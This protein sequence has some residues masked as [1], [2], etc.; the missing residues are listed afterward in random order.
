MTGRPAAPGPRT[1]RVPRW[2]SASHGRWPSAP[3]RLPAAGPFRLGRSPAPPPPQL[4]CSRSPGRWSPAERPPG[5]PA[6]PRT[7]TGPAAP[8]H[9]HRFRGSSAAPSRRPAPGATRSRARRAARG[10]GGLRPA[11]DGTSGTGSAHNPR[12]RAVADG[13]QANDRIGTPAGSRRHPGRQ[14]PD[15]I[16]RQ[17]ATTATTARCPVLD[18]VGTRSCGRPVLAPPTT[19]GASAQ[20]PPQHPALLARLPYPPPLGPL[21]PAE[22]RLHRRGPVGTPIPVRRHAVGPLMAS[23]RA[24]WPSIESR[25]DRRHPGQSVHQRQGLPRSPVSPRHGSR[26]PRGAVAMVIKGRA[27]CS[28]GRILHGAG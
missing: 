24:G 9:P 3:G 16:Q 6:E 18:P 26:P 13:P 8:R 27:A 19:V 4:R 1:P 7:R 17:P 25:W 14:R 28:C 5:R 20:R 15:L 22:G 2:P 21:E 12:R 11:A 10:P 23:R